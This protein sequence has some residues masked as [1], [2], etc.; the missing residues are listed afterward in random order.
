[1]DIPLWLQI[2]LQLLLQLALI[3]LNA[4]FACAEIAVIEIN[5]SKLDKLAESGNKRAKT[6]QTLTENPARFLATIQVAITLAGFLG[7]AFAADSFGEYIINAL[8]RSHPHLFPEWEG[9][10]DTLSVILITI[11][12]SYITLVFG[13]LVP[14]RV[15]MKNRERIALALTPT[16]HLVAV[17]FRPL[18]A[19]LTVS[20]NG[21][22]RLIGINPDEAESDV[23]EEEIRMMADAG[24]EQ[25]I[26]DEEENEMI[27]NVFNFDDITAKEIATHRT[28]ITFLWED[29]SDEEWE[30]IIKN[31]VYSHYPICLED[32]D[33]V[34]GILDAAAY[35]RLSDKSRASVLRHAVS[36]PYFA[37]EVMKINVLFREMK[38]E[39]VGM[40]IVVDEYGGT[41]GIVT[42]TDLIEEIVGDLEFCEENPDV[43]PHGN[44]YRIAG[45]A[46][47][48]LLCDRLA[49]RAEGESATV[50]GW[51]TE[52]LG[53]IPEV[54]DE[55]EA[56]GVHVLVS[57]ADDK[58]VLEI[59]AERVPTE[60]KTSTTSEE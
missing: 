21:V 47:K 2:A 24:S 12:L 30:S 25:G 41:C 19:L 39:H 37:S 16:I 1:M 20:T 26:I 55:F 14:K 31:H 49:L 28:E 45:Q 11:V 3:A 48:D 4:I 34:T 58:R 52:M 33:H 38:K 17:C 44:G 53:K 8:Q 42:K 10:I 5:G 60:N 35:L 18:V 7:S 23:S 32:L 57:D 22:L 40:A 54:G 6:L 59:Y 43:I 51:V 9:L 29:D 36:R 13:E 27:Q 15:A 50:S 56:D 46:E